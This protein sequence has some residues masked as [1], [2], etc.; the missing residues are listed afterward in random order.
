[1]FGAS[2]TYINQGTFGDSKI[3]CHGSCGGSGNWIG[4]VFITACCK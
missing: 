4:D 1:M 2:A 3:Q